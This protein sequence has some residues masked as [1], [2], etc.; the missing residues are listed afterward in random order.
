MKVFKPQK[1]SLLTRSFI[2]ELHPFLSVGV[3]SLHGWDGALLSEMEMW[4]FLGEQLGASGTA[5]VGMVKSR[6]EFLVT[7]SAH[8]PGGQPRP[9]AEVAVRIGEAHK[10]LRIFGD[11]IW[12]DGEVS[13][14]EPF[15]EMPITWENA[16]GGEDFARNPLGKGFVEPPPPATPDAP[17]AAAPPPR[18]LPNVEHPDSPTAR[19]S[20]VPEPVS[21][22]AIDFLWPQRQ[23]K[24]GTY[25]DAWFQELF[26]GHARDMDWTIFNI[27]AEDQQLPTGSF[28]G[29]EDFEIAGMHPDKP[30]L[31]GQLPKVVARCFVDLES[32]GPPVFQEIPLALTTV[33]FFPAA[34]RYLLVSHGAIEVAEDDAADVRNI[35]ISAEDLGEPR[36]LEHHVKVFEQ[37]SDP[38]E[39]PVHALNDAPLLPE[40]PAL[41]GSKD[42]GQAEMEGL[43]AREDFQRTYQKA[44]AERELEATRAGLVESGLDPDLYCP[45]PEP[46][47]EP[48]TDLD[49]V[50]AYSKEQTALAEQQREEAL[51]RSKQQEVELRAG[52]EAQGIDPDDY[53]AKEGEIP[54]GPPKFTAK[55]AEQE[56]SET[57]AEGRANGV[58][59]EPLEA[60]LVDPK[61]HEAW[62]KAEAS[63]REGYRLAAHHQ[64][65]A[66]R[67]EGDAAAEARQ[68]F[69]QALAA[70]GD[71]THLDLTGAD[72]SGLNLS[73]RDLS[74]AWME[75]ANLS[76][77]DLSGANL[78]GAVLAR[79]D[80]TATN[81]AGAKLQKA[82]SK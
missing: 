22:G 16:F 76:G 25:D 36:S 30:L 39:G 54:S 42:P 55:G 28:L 27:A 79:A 29:D 78:E 15:S 4:K 43:M 5:D 74:G 73:G 7:G 64:G 18:P 45:V 31:R 8:Q 59:I 13:E 14:P 71:L 77:A 33:W 11:R 37:R 38:E 21:F 40:S 66:P 53:L 44:R 49:Q 51:A 58:V 48:P 23:S 67:L 63:Y 32:D 57:L 20:E 35:L 9:T 26:P 68:G 81:L 70:G 61:Q 52:L 41:L 60:L 34:E 69:E 10:A 19:S 46:V 62:H 50:L 82:L 17:E 3:L 80:L 56:L 47:P 75:N 72:L 12:D 6:A 2:E 24:A 65:E 1:L